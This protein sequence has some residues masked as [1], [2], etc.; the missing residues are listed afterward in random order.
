MRSPLA[1]A[2]KPSQGKS[3]TDG[4]VQSHHAPLRA[5]NGGTNGR[6]ERAACR[7]RARIAAVAS[8]VAT[9]IGLAQ[10]AGLGQAGQSA[11]AFVG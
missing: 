9:E 5:Q 2:A 8:A 3:C 1:F 6:M 11:P 4:A 10:S 7:Q